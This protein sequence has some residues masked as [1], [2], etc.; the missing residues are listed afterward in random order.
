L[1]EDRSAEL[2]ES[3]IGLEQRLQ[4]MGFVADEILKGGADSV[5]AP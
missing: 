3:I 4:A 1:R 5:E 2:L